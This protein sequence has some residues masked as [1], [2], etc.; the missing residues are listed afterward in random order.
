M[1]ATSA[2]QP[3]AVNGSLDGGHAAFAA[4]VAAASGQ[5]QAEQLLS[6]I[7]TTGSGE[8]FKRLYARPEYRA[9]I[10]AYTTALLKRFEDDPQAFKAFQEVLARYDLEVSDRAV[11]LVAAA[12]IV[13][14]SAG[15]GFV[16]GLVSG[17]LD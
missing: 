11:P 8:F 4:A 14:G 3:R 12:W 13:G 6:L 15:A 9:L 5:V 17:L 1:D 2:L 7:R 16:I 10:N